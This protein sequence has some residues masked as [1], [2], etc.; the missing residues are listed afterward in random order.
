[1]SAY[2]LKDDITTHTHTHTH[3]HTDCP[4]E[5]QK[6]HCSEIMLSCT[7]LGDESGSDESVSHLVVSNSL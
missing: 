3:T 6:L 2:I 1:M 4:K 5:E 7:S